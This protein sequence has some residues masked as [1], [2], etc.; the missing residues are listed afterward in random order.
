MKHLL[1]I[2]TGLNSILLILLVSHRIDTYFT[3]DSIWGVLIFGFMSFC[4]LY[5]CL[6]V[7]KCIIREE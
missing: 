3:P 7:I 4:I 6:A 2:M 1:A 5:W